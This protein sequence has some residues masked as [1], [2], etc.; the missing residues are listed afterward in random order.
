MLGQHSY[1]SY[2]HAFFHINLV[3]KS[4]PID[5]YIYNNKLYMLN[6]LM[7]LNL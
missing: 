3:L 1:D 5:L 4:K 2:R 6:A 7:D